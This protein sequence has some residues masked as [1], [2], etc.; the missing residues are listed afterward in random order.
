M[1]ENQ[2]TTNK[3]LIA[4]PNRFV[5]GPEKKRLTPYQEEQKRIKEE[6]RKERLS[7]NAPYPTTN[8]SKKIREFERALAATQA[9]TTP[10]KAVKPDVAPY[11][12]FFTPGEYNPQSH[13]LVE[14]PPTPVQPKNLFVGDEEVVDDFGFDLDEEVPKEVGGKKRKSRKLRRT[15]KKL[16]KSR[17]KTRKVRRH[18]RRH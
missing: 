1:S 4:N 10:S 9:L 18:R 2:E 7:K 8:T 3:I 12:D 16:R 13:D 11:G 14:M 17:R 5:S 6:Q 15:T